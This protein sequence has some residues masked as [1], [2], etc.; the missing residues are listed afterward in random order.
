MG[1]AVHDQVFY[2]GVLSQSTSR[3]GRVVEIIHRPPASDGSPRSMV[4]RV[5]LSDVASDY[6][7]VE[8]LAEQFVL[9]G[10]ASTT[11]PPPPKKKWR[12]QK[13]KP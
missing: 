10:A 4:L 1:V 13:P 3:R 12:Y 11:P 8:D 9:A 7:I 2:L 6:D 5:V